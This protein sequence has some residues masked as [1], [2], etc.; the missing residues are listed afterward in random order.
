MFSVDN[1]IFT[2]WGQGLSFLE[3]FALL[4]G[5]CSVFLAVRGKVLNFWAGYLYNIL[6]FLMFI[7]KHLYS[8]MLLQ[9]VSFGIN[10]F[11]H[12]RWTHPKQG[13]KDMK[14]ELR[15][16]TLT[17][18][19][20][21]VIIAIALVFTVLWGFFLSKVN[22]LWPDFPEARQPFLDAFVTAMIL[23]AQ[24]LSAQKKIECWAVWVIVNI[25]NGILYIKVGLVFMPVVCA[26][27]LVLA[28]MGFFMWKKKM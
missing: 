21:L 7:Q 18:R 10:F 22:L 24:Y 5:L 12:Y 20:R 9:P 3:L 23:V 11:G 2:L 4:C 16:T 15:V 19:G 17:L 27:Y 13:E 25:T 28:F 26:A 1:I 8:S 14:E 6:L